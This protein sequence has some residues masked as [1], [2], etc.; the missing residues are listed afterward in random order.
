MHLPS[1]FK[2]CF[3]GCAETD[4]HTLQS[5][6]FE[7]KDNHVQLTAV[8]CRLAGVFLSDLQSRVCVCVCVVDLRTSVFM[9]PRGTRAKLTIKPSFL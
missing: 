7:V 2:L 3:S 1:L 5:D 9:R 4:R 8:L 6:D